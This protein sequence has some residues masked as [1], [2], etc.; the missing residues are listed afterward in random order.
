MDFNATI[1]KEV[2]I[3]SKSVDLQLNV[4]ANHLIERSTLFID[5]ISGARSFD[6]A[7][8]EFGLPKWNG[9]AT[10]RADVDKWRFT[11]QVDY[12]GA[13]EQDEAGIDPFSDAFGRGPD[14]HSDR[15]TVGDTC[16]GNG[17]GTF[18]TRLQRC[19][20]PNGRVPGT[21]VFCR[22]VGFAKEQFLHTA[23]I[24]YRGDKFDVLAGVSNI[25][26]TAPPLVDSSE[27]LAIGNTA[28]GSGYDYDGRE[29]FLQVQMKF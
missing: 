7:A 28:I 10:F 29:F 3:G 25:F 13:V 17:S 19:S 16:L 18:S 5:P 12:T 15:S 1:G 4:R 6:D 11:W 20:P 2:L 23:S 21:N 22:D 9:R 27:V 26:N 14:G 24:R 8:G